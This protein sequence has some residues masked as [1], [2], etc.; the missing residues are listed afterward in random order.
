MIKPLTSL[1]F[2][3]AFM[4]FASHIQFFDAATYPQYAH[5]YELVMG[6]GFIGVSFFFILSGFI[7]SLNYDERLLSR[8]VSF[9]EFWVA[10]IAR[11]Y[12]LHLVTMLLALGLMLYSAEE[13][14]GPFQN[15]ATGLNVLFTNATLLQAFIPEMPYYFSYNWPSWSISDEMF[16]YFT[17]PF[18]VFLLVRNKLLLRF[19]WVLFLAVPFLMQV[20]QEDEYHK[21]FYINPFF[22]LVDFL[23][24]IA[25]HQVYK[26]GFVGR[27][28]RSRLGATALEVLS[29]AAFVTVFHFHRDFAIV[30]R[31]SCYYWLPIAFVILSFSYQRGYLSTLLSGRTMV[32]LG[33]ISFSFYLIHQLVIRWLKYENDHRGLFDNM[34]V[35]AALIFVLSMV[36][37][38]LLHRFVEMPSNHYIKARY[39]RSRFGPVPPLVAPAVAAVPVAE[40]IPVP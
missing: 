37:S 26:Q 39:K 14:A 27:A 8:R 4:V 6:E 32:L 11:V 22:R 7:L 29:L 35:L 3:F 2:L 19:G 36:L 38:Y 13:Y 9:R 25:L 17:F 5:W 20:S 34:Y 12:P 23:L 30:Y 18:V 1:R 28:Y 10:R 15:M 24:G 40:A 31:Y 16:F 33:E 21:L